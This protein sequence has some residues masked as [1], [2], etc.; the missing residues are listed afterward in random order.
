MASE[1]MDATL[2]CTNHRHIAQE[3]LEVSEL[4]VR[5]RSKQS[6]ASGRFAIDTRTSAQQRVPRRALLLRLRVL[7]GRHA[8]RSHSQ[9]AQVGLVGREDGAQLRQH[10]RLFVETC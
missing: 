2:S 6:G 9:L 8:V 3:A 5:E 10:A 1:D 7:E 4:F